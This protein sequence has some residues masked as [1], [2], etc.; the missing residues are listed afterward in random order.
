MGLVLSTGF[1]I[2]CL[3]YLCNFIGKFNTHTTFICDDKNHSDE[4][5]SN[6]IWQ[7]H[8]LIFKVNATI[9]T[10]KSYFIEEFSI[11]TRFSCADKN[12]SPE[13]TFKLIWRCHLDIFKVSITS[14][15]KR[16]ICRKAGSREPSRIPEKKLAHV[17]RKSRQLRRLVKKAVRNNFPKSSNIH[18]YTSVV[19]FQHLSMYGYNICAG[20]KKNTFKRKLKWRNRTRLKNSSTHSRSKLHKLVK[21]CIRLHR[22]DVFKSLIQ[23]INYCK[24]LLS[25]DVE[26]NPGPTIVDQRKT[27]AAPYSQ[28]N[29]LVFGT[30]NTGRQCVAMSLSALICN[31]RKAITCSADLIQV[32][33]IG[34][35]LYSTL[36]QSAKQLFLL[37]TDL[38]AM[39]N[40]F[41]TNYNL[42]YRKSYSGILNRNSICIEDFP[43][44]M[45]LASAFDSLLRDNY[46]SFLLTI[47]SYTVGIYSL[48][49]DRCKIFNSHSKDLSGMTHPLSTCT[50]I[51]IDSLDNLVQYFQNFHAQTNNTTYEVKGLTIHEMQIDNENYTAGC[52][53]DCRTIENEQDIL[54]LFKECCAISFYFIC[55]SII[56][57]CIY[58][59][60]DTVESIVENGKL[61]YQEYFFGKQTFISDLPNKLNISTGDVGVVYEARSQGILCYSSSISKENLKRYISDNK[62]K[63]TGFGFGFQLLH[64]LYISIL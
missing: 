31:F 1:V 11:Y 58:W 26:K 59:N 13:R 12:Q 6:V 20:C 10:C 46:N 52:S 63:S 47:G 27:I 24:Y 2:V 19:V 7:S 17:L 37:L 48:P 50:L 62:E 14:R 22:S 4:I 18:H 43:F 41:E 33:K 42:R 40:L 45:S 34:N 57:S 29:V 21:T 54:F 64:Q 3:V 28:S 36:S 25:R 53:T 51:E 8:L 44:V 5:T 61:F 32:M 9:T 49:N 38:P 30:S 16:Q 56:K 35:N 60:S 55:F 39:V 23:R 15:S